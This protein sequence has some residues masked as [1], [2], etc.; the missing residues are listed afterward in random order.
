M[1]V[2]Y[3]RPSGAAAPFARTTAPVM[4]HFNHIYAGLFLNSPLLRRFAGR[5]FCAY[6]LAMGVF[7]DPSRASAKR[8]VFDFRGSLPYASGCNAWNFRQT[9]GFVPRDSG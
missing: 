8:G 2:H 9:I 6:M 5:I 7:G 1:D 4:R 3:S